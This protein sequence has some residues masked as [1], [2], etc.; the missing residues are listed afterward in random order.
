MSTTIQRLKL[1]T[2]ENNEDASITV[3]D[4][5]DKFGN[6][7]GTKVMLLIPFTYK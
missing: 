1:L 4:L 7:S 5:Y 3:E 2:E 6:A